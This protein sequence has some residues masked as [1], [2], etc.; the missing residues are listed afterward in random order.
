[1]LSLVPLTV[2][3]GTHRWICKTSE[4]EGQRRLGERKSAFA[5]EL[6]WHITALSGV[7]RTAHKNTGHGVKAAHPDSCSGVYRQLTLPKATAVLR[8]EIQSSSKDWDL[9]A[10]LI[11]RFI[12]VQRQQ[13]H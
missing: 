3:P 9:H 4:L 11:T 7:S 12:K 13:Q 6:L 2:A 5:Q 1:M 10:R 8:T